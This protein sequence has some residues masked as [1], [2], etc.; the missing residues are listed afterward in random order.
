MLKRNELRI[1]DKM[2]KGARLVRTHTRMG[3]VYHLTTGEELSAAT[4]TRIIEHPQVLAGGDG[5]W[6]DNQSWGIE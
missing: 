1:L 4:A 5:M 6:G 3:G 2:R